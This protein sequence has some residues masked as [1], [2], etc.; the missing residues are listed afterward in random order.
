[1]M[2]VLHRLARAFLVPVIFLSVLTY[3]AT[4]RAAT[5]ATQV[6]EMREITLTADRAYDNPYTEVTVW[7]DLQGQGIKK[8][9]HGFWDGGNV[10][11]I[12]L[13]ATA[14]GEWTW[15]TGSNQDDGGLNGKRGGFEAA[16]WSETQKRAN[17]NRRGFVR[18]TAN[19]HAL[20]YADGTP[21]FLMADTW[22]SASTRVWSW[23]S[24]AGDARISFQDAVK[25]RKAQGYNG[26]TMIASFPNW[27]EDGKPARIRDEKGVIIRGH[28]WRTQDMVD[29]SGGRPF[30]MREDMPLVADYDRL[31]PGYFQHLDHK[32]QYLSDQ[33]FVPFF[34]TV[35]RDHGP[36]WKAYTPDWERSF[37]RYVG[38][39][40]SR[41]GAYNMIFSVLHFDMKGESIPV[42]DWQAAIRVT[43]AN[44]CTSPAACIT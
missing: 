8:C 10:F 9:V 42:K 3:A 39:L 11:K 20:Q 25:T 27:A 43:C 16:D 35:R 41:Y 7:A 33:G 36:T 2:S 6:W 32:M 19:G 14:P 26:I 29:E 4:A 38:Y 5:P 12:R 40:A 24:A 22:W 37:A 30:E 17:P 34:E 13:V 31:C 15:R 21:F 28:G 1:M 23:G 18:A 44:T